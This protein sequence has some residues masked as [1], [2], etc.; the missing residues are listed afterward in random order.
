MLPEVIVGFVTYKLSLV[1]HNGHCTHLE[2]TALLHILQLANNKLQTLLELLE[3]FMV[4]LV[5]LIYEC[6]DQQFLVI[7]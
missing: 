4:S 1:F 7:F 6:L 3:A 5:I 2:M